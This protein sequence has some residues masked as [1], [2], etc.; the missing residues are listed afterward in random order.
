MRS[1]RA[2]SI[3]G[4][5]MR[6]SIAVALVPLII[7]AIAAVLGVRQLGDDAT[8]R[9]D[10]SRE[11]LESESVLVASQEQAISVAREINLVLFERI[12]DVRE[13][14]RNTEVISGAYAARSYVRTE[15]IADLSIDTLEGRFAGTKNTGQAETARRFL[16][17]EL[18]NNQSFSAVSFTD[19][20]GFN[21]AVTD[22]SG[23]FVQSDEE[24]W[25]QAWTNGIHVDDIELDESTNEFSIDIAVRID[26]SASGI[27]LGVIHTT[28]D[29]QFVDAIANARSTNA[30]KYTVALADGK[31]ISET[32]RNDPARLMS[33]GLFL[34]PGVLAAL[35]A[36]D[37]GGLVESDTV[38]GFTNTLDPDFFEAGA[39]G[40]PGF[41]W[42]VVSTQSSETAFA[43]LEGLQDLRTDIAD[44]ESDLVRT[45]LLVLFAA[46][47]LAFIMGRL[48]ARAIT[49]PILTLTEAA[50][51]SAE[52]G[53]PG[54]VKR[55]NEDGADIE[56]VSVDEVT[57]AT[58]DELEELAKSFNSVQNTAVSLAAKQALSRRNTAEMFVNLGRRN[59]SLLKRQLRFI[60]D[61]EKNE[62]DPDTLDS[63]FKLDHLATRMRR[64]A[65]S[66]LVL[67]GDRSPRRWAAPVPVRD[68]VQAALAEVEGYERVDFDRMP[69]GE[70]QGNVAADAAHILAELIENALNFSPPNSQVV[71]IGLDEDDGYVLTISDEGLGM[72]P[73]E[74]EAANQRLAT[75]RDLSE[76]PSQYLGL[77]VVSRLADR[78]GI[79]VALS[80]A[81]TG[82]LTARVL[83]PESIT[84]PKPTEEPEPASTS[85]TGDDQALND[86]PEIEK[87][88]AEALAM[89]AQAEQALA[90]IEDARKRLSGTVRADS[91]AAE[92][93]QADLAA[94]AG[95]DADKSSDTSSPE[96]EAAEE[97]VVAKAKKVKAK[98]AE[99]TKR[100]DKQLEDAKAENSEVESSKVEDTIED[101]VDVEDD[102]EDEMATPEARPKAGSRK[103]PAERTSEETFGRRSDDVA[104]EAPTTPSAGSDD[105]VDPAEA[106]T[107][108]AVDVGGLTFARRGSKSATSD[109]TPPKRRSEDKPEPKATAKSTKTEDPEDPTTDLERYGFTRRESKKSTGSSSAVNT[110][111]DKEPETV[112][113]EDAMVTA[114]HSLNRWSRFQ[115]G[116]EDALGADGEETPSEASSTKSD[117]EN[118][119]TSSSES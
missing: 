86:D 30:T 92:D 88:E 58:G 15:G 106:A 109:A 35:A 42:V 79:E 48:M 85:S 31:L 36:P 98:E 17:S 3:R 29:A 84:K 44:S 64:N 20:N 77:F 89:L 96:I 11:V 82:G 4:K 83:L 26:D 19:S 68:A 65:E 104:S 71:V 50:S 13:W 80:A 25:Q 108:E 38:Y 112:T 75:F 74:L 23:D 6:R 27:R 91:E 10:E 47:I 94:D 114:E 60:D 63:L 41:D 12:A 1:L 110:K 103:S 119:P 90:R 76:V 49:G 117:I 111:V 115:R 62:A 33:P 45:I 46:L 22:S 81:P 21:A 67:A 51:A 28:L 57:I 99:D 39:E 118:L 78:H 101:D 107:G 53:L 59:Q 105:S 113:E 37:G 40:F 2:K 9:V 87:A 34:N 93:A 8:R 55:I 66:L 24:W 61:L 54:A 16:E 69:K 18:A 43:P 72:N 102:V 32:A 70:I 7:L 97:R 52:S 5:I 100:K 116:K 73:E 14:S 56:S 95:A